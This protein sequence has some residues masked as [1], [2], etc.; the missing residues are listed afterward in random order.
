MRIS[1]D[2]PVLEPNAPIF[3]ED[4][5]I[6]HINGHRLRET[7]RGRVAVGLSPTIMPSI[8]SDNLP[9]ELL[10]SRL[11]SPFV[12]TTT[13]GSRIEVVL[14]RI[15][16]VAGSARRTFKGT[17]GP[18]RSPCVVM[19]PDARVD[20]VSFSVLNSLSDLDRPRGLTVHLGSGPRSWWT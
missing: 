8:E 20:S 7:C 12:I 14:L 5:G 19:K 6:T 10:D 3:L 13:T 4:V 9:A 15:S 18:Y 17:L 1:S 11:E 16:D 2:S